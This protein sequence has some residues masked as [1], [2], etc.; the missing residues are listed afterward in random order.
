MHIS[1]LESRPF[2]R[3]G[4]LNAS[5]RGGPE[6]ASLP[7]LRARVHRLPVGVDGILIASDLQGVA[8][9]WRNGGLTRLLG[10][11]LADVFCELGDRGEVPPAGR[12]G[13]VL[14]GDL[15]SFPEANRRGGH[16]DV[17]SVWRAFASRFAW[18]VGVEGNH[19]GFGSDRER[20]RFESQPGVHLLDGTV[21]DLDMSEEPWVVGGVGRV[22]GRY[23]RVGRRDEGDFLAGLDLVLEQRPQLVV[24]HE[25]PNG[26]GSRQPGNS[27]LRE[28]FV[29]STVPL[30][31]CGHSHWDDP[32]ATIERG[33]TVLNV[34]ARAVLLTE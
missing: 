2:H 16:G 33:P 10:E 8:A 20:R 26:C 19:D 1:E 23:A 17:R 27:T 28:R 13:V 5:K 7:I 30:V 29:E 6:A 3:I 11:E 14:A 9:D 31:V 32:L 12:T 34:D 15:F 22:I 25:G 4:Y 24:L 21:V 18:V